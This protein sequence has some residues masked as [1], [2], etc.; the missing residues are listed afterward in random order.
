VRF[1]K[2]IKPNRKWLIASV[3]IITACAGAASG[4][5]TLTAADPQAQETPVDINPEETIPAEDESVIQPLETP[6]PVPKVKPELL[7]EEE[8][9]LNAD[10]QF[11]T[12]FSRHTVPYSDVLSGGPPKDG[13]PAIDN[14]LF[15][16]VSEADEYLQD[17]EPVIFFQVGED[18]RAYPLQVL[19]WHEIVNDVVDGKPVAI[20]FC[21]LCNTA[22]AFD[23]TFDGQELDFGTTGRL[24]F[25]NLIMY[26][27]QTET[28]WQQATGEGIAGEYAG[29]QLTFL[30]ASII[31]WAEFKDEFPDGKVLSRET[32][33]VRDY[34][35]NP[36][37]GYDNINSSPFLFRGPETP[38]VLPAMARVL[39][40][41][42]DGEAVAFPYELLQ[43]QSVINDTISGS[44]V[45]VFWQPGTASAL[46]SSRIAEG[47]D[48][49]AGVAFSPIVDGQ[50]LTFSLVDGKIIDD[51]TGSQ[52][53]VFGQATSGELSGTQLEPVVS[54]NHFWFSWAAFKP[55]TRIYQQ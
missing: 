3:L 29:E 21:P 9:P 17:L 50:V 39:T 33:F 48:V 46:D 26:D 14:P 12:D 11:T 36:Y 51:Q 53:D 25:S 22:I 54:V 24:R 10:F 52:W 18:A 7:P 19:T 4:E 35:R 34:G 32:G 45:V 16:S 28:W 44:K 41:D 2:F 6:L 40:V 13:I 30:P 27:R 5:S 55:E 23:A 31:G 49:G 37:A 43:E 8:P 1:P 38:G 42:L 15:T 47:D 20:T